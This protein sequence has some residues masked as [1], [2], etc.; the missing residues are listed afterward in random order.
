[1]QTYED[2]GLFDVVGEFTIYI[3]KRRPEVDAV[4]DEFAARHKAIRIMGTAEN[5]GIL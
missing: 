3:N 1:M 5:V 4:A 2:L